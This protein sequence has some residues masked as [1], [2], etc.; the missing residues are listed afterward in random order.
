MLRKKVFQ[1]NDIAIIMVIVV[2]VVD[3]IVDVVGV[4]TEVALWRSC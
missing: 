1:E 4:V 3:I 2:A